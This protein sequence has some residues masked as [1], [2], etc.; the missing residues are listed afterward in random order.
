MNGPIDLR[1][2]TR[3]Y[4]DNYTI[5]RGFEL[6]GTKGGLSE[7]QELIAVKGMEWSLTHTHH[8]SHTRAPHTYLYTIVM[9]ASSADRSFLPPPLYR[10]NNGRS[11]SSSSSPPSPSVAFPW[12]HVHY[13]ATQTPEIL[14]WLYLNEAT[15]NQLSY[16]EFK[17]VPPGSTALHVAVVHKQLERSVTNTKKDARSSTS[18]EEKDG[19]LF[20]SCAFLFLRLLISFR[21]R[22]LPFFSFS[23]PLLS[24]SLHP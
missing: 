2:H 1:L 15:M 12:S 14:R 18:S 24:L 10:L 8:T 23:S 22:L 3:E 6:C 4:Y 21:C 19:D 7:L 20:V 16:A 13:A 17:G 9:C 5:Q 11:S